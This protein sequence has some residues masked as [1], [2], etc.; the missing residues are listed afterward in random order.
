MPRII[1]RGV[2]VMYYKNVDICDLDRIVEQG[3]LPISKCGN[4]NWNDLKM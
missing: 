2:I 1:P 4:D 3:I